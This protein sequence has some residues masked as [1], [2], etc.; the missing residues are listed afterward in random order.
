MTASPPNSKSNRPTAAV[1]PTRDREATRSA[2]L[3]AAENEFAR[4]GFEG[5][6]TEAIAA[7][8]GVTKAMIHYY[9]GSKELLYFA[10]LA[11]GYNE[12]LEPVERLDLGA[13]APD[14]ALQKFVDC[15]LD[16]L[17]RH[18]NFPAIMSYEA[19][20]NQGS[21]YQ[22]L[23]GPNLCDR[24]CEIL[25]RGVASGHFRPLD[26]C[27]ASINI[28]GV[29]VF[30]FIGRGNIQHRIPEGNLLS[31]PMLDRHRQEAI[32]SILAG[33]RADPVPPKR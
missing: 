28:M 13:L 30:Y 1:R 20:Q 33:V 31:P 25:E 8:A 5:T 17:S 3:N 2:I 16:S 18:P 15:V 9:F 7:Q 4:H 23:D 29:C 24:L 27:H 12:Y 11:R 22:R 21:Y 10:V 14:K 19:L 6:R 26:P 32:A